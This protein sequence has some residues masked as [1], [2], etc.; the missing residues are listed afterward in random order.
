MALG[1]CRAVMLAS[2]S[3]AV[4]AG[5]AVA[6][7][8]CSDGQRLRQSRPGRVQSSNRNDLLTA[9]NFEN[10]FPGAAGRRSPLSLSQPA[11]TRSIQA[12]PRILG[13]ALATET[14]R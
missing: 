2:F 6:Q 8:N 13:L 10:R 11:D 12:C 7:A 3:L 14:R 9:E 4:L 5:P 1:Y